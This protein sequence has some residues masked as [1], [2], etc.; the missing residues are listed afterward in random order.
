MILAG[1]PSPLKGAVQP[2]YT[3]GSQQASSPSALRPRDNHVC[4]RHPPSKSQPLPPRK[5]HSTTPSL[6]DQAIQGERQVLLAQRSHVR[7]E[8]KVGCT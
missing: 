4:L 5:E 1:R 7:L 2:I 3:E 6:P 8:D